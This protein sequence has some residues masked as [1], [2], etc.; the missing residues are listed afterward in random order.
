[1]GAAANTEAPAIKDS[2]RPNGLRLNRH[3]NLSRKPRRDPNAADRPARVT[4]DRKSAQ[5]RNRNLRRRAA[6][7]RRPADSLG[8]DGASKWRGRRGRSPR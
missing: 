3:S 2:R 1:V 8:A 4:A 7:R 6:R 5:R